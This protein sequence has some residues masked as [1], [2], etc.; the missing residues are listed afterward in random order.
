MGWIGHTVWACGNRD[1]MRATITA[2]GH[3]DV[4]EYGGRDWSGID[5]APM[6]RH[7]SPL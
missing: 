1:W 4:E 2:A 6:D 7:D 3:F 5:R